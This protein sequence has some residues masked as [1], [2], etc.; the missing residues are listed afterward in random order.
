M[1][2]LEK[3][4][5]KIKEIQQALTFQKDQRVRTITR[6]ERYDAELATTEK[7]ESELL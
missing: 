7:I 5:S 1:M 2:R 6:M 3:N 4:H